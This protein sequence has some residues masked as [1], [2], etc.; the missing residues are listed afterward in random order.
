MLYK[1]TQQ[2]R[3]GL[4]L[5]RYLPALALIIPAL[6]CPANAQPIDPALRQ[7]DW[8]AEGAVHGKAAYRA[9]AEGRWIVTVTGDGSLGLA[10]AEG[11]PPLPLVSAPPVRRYDRIEDEVGD[12][13]R[14]FEPAEVLRT[15]TARFAAG[16]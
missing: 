5:R 6:P 16:R 14:A 11:A 2:I 15:L 3:G 12:A 13:M 4:L 9:L 8:Q 1:R 7:V 10:R